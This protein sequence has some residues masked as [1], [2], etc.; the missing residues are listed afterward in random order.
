MHFFAM[1][2]FRMLMLHAQIRLTRFQIEAMVLA[3]Q[4]CELANQI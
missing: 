1:T 4:R 2:V 3:D